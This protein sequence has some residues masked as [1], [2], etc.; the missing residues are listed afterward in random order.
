MRARMMAA[1]VAS[2][3]LIGCGGGSSASSSTADR[4]ASDS[5][6][7]V[8]TAAAPVTEAPPATEA[9][10][11]PEPVAT[12]PLAAAGGTW[13]VLLYSIADTDLEPF[14]MADVNEMGEVG[15]GNGLE[16]VALVDR[17]TDHG[18]DPVLD[19]GAWQGAKVLHVGQGTAEVLQD[20]G[21]LN[22]GDPQVLADF[23][24]Q[25][26]TSYPAEHYAVI[27]SDHGASWPGVGG[28]ESSDH[29]SLSLEEIRAGIAGGLETAGVAQLDLLGFDAC[30]M[31]TYEVASALAPL[32]QRMIASEELEPGHG[33]DYRSLGVL[34]TGEP[35]DVD[36]LGNAILDGYAAQAKAED[37][38]SNITLSLLDMTKMPA[39]EEAVA[40]FAAAISERADTI[41]SVLG[42]TRATTIGFGSSPDPTEDTQMTDIGQLVSKIGVESLDLSDP[43]DAVLRA[44]GD[45]VLRTVEGPA[46][47]DSTGLSVYFPPTENLL[48]ADY[49]TA[50]G[51]SPWLK[52]LNDY[53]GAGRNIAPE[54]EPAFLPGADGD[55]AA[56]VSFGPDGLTITGT[57][58]AAT[59]ANV[60]SAG[61]SYGLVQD[62][63]ST[64][65]IGEEPAA[66]PDAD[67]LVSG[68][69][70][71][72]TF[73]ISDG[74][75]TA[76]AY[77][78]LDFDEETGLATIDVPMAYY[79][80]GDETGETYQDALLSLTVEA[81]T[82]D[83]VDE[84]YYVYD[85]NLDT[86][87]ELSADPAG[88]IVPEVFVY[89]ADGVGEWLPFEG[90]ELTADL[91]SLA[92]DFVP[93]A[94]GTRLYIDLSVTDFGGNSAL[95]SAEVT[96]P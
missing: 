36:T 82:F 73:T 77:L 86:Y 69:Y 23:I 83:V 89:S 45:V 28:D 32:T 90:V 1:I 61:I 81:E 92:Y 94:S 46:M 15:S 11:A 76:T 68:L 79:A 8:T 67:G 71:L 33:W 20:V 3:A 43:A 39:M 88:T 34:V 38:A 40:G 27:L 80:P 74:T 63:G 60:V 47:L 55:G 12:D 17:S 54:A 62:D 44:L 56:D 6:A 4:S 19:V 31:A 78:V 91:P 87:G 30:L 26:I 22:T 37:T 72:T 42:G 66:L 59:T 51:D 14:M 2:V 49:A 53:Y 7:A 25:G 70:D 21:D 96:V 65:F 50:V 93:L 18:D 35:V 75:S 41:G 10:T 52:M 48:N 57:L 5:T 58:D 84:T 13:T 16:L 9:T 24:A 29:D 64:V 85:E 95:V